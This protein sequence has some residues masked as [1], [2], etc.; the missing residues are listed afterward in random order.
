MEV[1]V[2]F[3]SVELGQSPFGETPE[4]FNAIDVNAFPVRE[5]LGL[6]DPE[7]LA[8]AYVNQPIIPPPAIGVNPRIRAYTFEDY[9]LKRFAAAVG[10]EFGVYLSVA[11]E[12]TKNWTLPGSPPPFMNT[13]FAS[14]ALRSEVGLIKFYFFREQYRLKGLNP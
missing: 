8:I 3:H 1:K 10:N 12:Y 13:H 11:F 5:M 9:L 4:R 14:D 6:I 7:V 2:G